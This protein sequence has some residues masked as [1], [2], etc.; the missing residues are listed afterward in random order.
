M[1]SVVSR[2]STM[3]EKIREIQRFKN[4]IPVL[5]IH[6][7]TDG[8]RYENNFFDSEEAVQKFANLHGTKTVIYDIRRPKK[9]AEKNEHNFRH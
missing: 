2:F 8:F 7:E 6:V 5:F 9:G 3:E 1:K 4:F